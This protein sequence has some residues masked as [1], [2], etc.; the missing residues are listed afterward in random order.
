MS[1]NELMTMFV[2]VAGLGWAKKFL[3]DGLSHDGHDPSVRAMLRAIL[4]ALPETVPGKGLLIHAGHEF[5]NF[6][7]TSNDN[8]RQS[9]AVMD[10]RLHLT[11]LIAS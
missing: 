10:S 1:T 5:C 4:D 7:E 8:G 3:T 11:E 2:P 6:Y 9:L